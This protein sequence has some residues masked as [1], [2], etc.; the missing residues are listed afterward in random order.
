MAFRQYPVPG[1]CPVCG[2]AFTVTQVKCQDCGARLE[3]RF[4]PGLLGSL[5]EEQIRF[6]RV[7]LASRGNIREMGKELGISYPTVRSR[8]DE[9]LEAL[10][11]ASDDEPDDVLEKVRRGKLPVE[12]AARIIADWHEEKEANSDE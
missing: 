2:G 12:E 4:T 10:G 1:T 5:T 7:F 11:L 8:L 6:V 3:G 9:I